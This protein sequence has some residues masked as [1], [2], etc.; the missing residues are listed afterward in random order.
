MF[1]GEPVPRK[2]GI[3][4]VTH[5]ELFT[6]SLVIIGIVGLFLQIHKRK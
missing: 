1:V 5:S 3:A 6:Y 2:G 4:M